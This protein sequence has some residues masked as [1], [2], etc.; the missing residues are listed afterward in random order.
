MLAL[1]WEE[2]HSHAVGRTLSVESDV[3]R[4]PEWLEQISAS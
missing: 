2:V 4:M 1:Y 3:C